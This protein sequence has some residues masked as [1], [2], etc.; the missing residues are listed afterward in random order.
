MENESRLIYETM[1][2]LGR[3]GQIFRCNAGRFYTKSGQPV[4]GLP[5]G[6]S[7]LLY[8]GSDGVA[9]FIE[10]KTGKNKPT[11]EQTTFIEKMKR[12]GCAAGV[13]YSV[14][15]AAQIC[16]IKTSKREVKA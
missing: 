8:I 11:P 6:F 1:Q 9:C 13:A 12:L 2:T 16:G 14:E 15:E 10:C 5:K 3:H 7:D 4:S